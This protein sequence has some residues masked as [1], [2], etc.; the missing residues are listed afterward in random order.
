MPGSCKV[1]GT[2]HYEEDYATQRIYV[3]CRVWHRIYIT[4]KV[5]YAED[6][7]KQRIYVTC[8]VWHGIYGK[9]PL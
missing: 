2:V 8:E 3:T 6:Y 1:D 9:P 7:V 4:C 5:D